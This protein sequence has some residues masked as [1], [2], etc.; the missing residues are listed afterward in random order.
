MLL[1]TPEPQLDDSS[2]SMSSGG[3]LKSLRN[4]LSSYDENSQALHALG[5]GT[6]LEGPL[7]FSVL[8]RKLD[9]DTRHRF[10]TSRADPTFDTPAPIDILFGADLFAQTMTG[11]Q[12][13][14]RKDLPIAFGT[15]FGVVLKGPTPCSTVSV[16]QDHFN[17]FVANRI[18]QIQDWLPPHT[19]MHIA[20]LHNPADLSSQGLSPTYLNDHPLGWSGP[21]WLFLPP[22]QWP[23]SRFTPVAE[24]ALPD[25]KSS[26]LNVI[27]VNPATDSIETL[28]LKH[29]LWKKLVNAMALVL[30]FFKHC[31]SKNRQTGLLSPQELTEAIQCICRVVQA[32]TFI[33]DHAFF[34]VPGLLQFKSLETPRLHYDAQT[35]LDQG[36]MEILAYFFAP[37]GLLLLINLF[38]FAATAWEL[39]CGLWKTEVVKASTER[40]ALG[41]VCVKL[42]IM[43]GL[44]WVLDIISWAVGGPSYL[45]YLP[46]LL[47]TLQG[48]FIFI[49]VGCHPQVWA[50][51]KRNCL[52]ER[53]NRTLAR[54]QLSSVSQASRSAL[55]TTNTTKIIPLETMC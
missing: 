20:S 8:L 47:N 34:L 41:R 51:V 52:G 3:S 6:A 1:P 25:V 9:G 24:A 23:L 29:S 46:D 44:T 7:V 42:V 18:P 37:L 19:W 17:V 27:I 36:D 40:A 53:T 32:V 48:V 2:H 21:P 55:D 33:A 28:L 10:E 22:K 45:W 5:Q 16:P 38:L 31:K 14:L 50:A 54:H 11:E 15:V 4:M 13:I 26:P 30:H 12:Y 39:T 43:M 49:V 35:E